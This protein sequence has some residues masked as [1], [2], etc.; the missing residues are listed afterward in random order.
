MVPVTLIP[1]NGWVKNDTNVPVMISVKE[2]VITFYHAHRDKS[3]QFIMS[4]LKQRGLNERSI[5]RVL[6]GI[7]DGSVYAPR[8]KAGRKFIQLTKEERR[9]LRNLVDGRISPSMKSLEAKFGRHRSVIERILKEMGL[10]K[11]ARTQ[12]PKVSPGQRQKERLAT[13]LAPGGSLRP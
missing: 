9:R 8:K 13:A 11:R 7:A 1:K 12:V 4:H 2:Q 10:K 5:R 3:R 6:Q